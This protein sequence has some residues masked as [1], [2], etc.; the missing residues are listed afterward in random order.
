MLGHIDSACCKNIVEL[1]PSSTQCHHATAPQNMQ[2]SL[3]RFFL[4]KPCCVHQWSLLRH[5]QVK[6]SEESDNF[7]AD[8][9]HLASHSTPNAWVLV[10]QTRE[11][12]FCSFKDVRPLAEM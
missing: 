7:C 2:I 11:I 9:A 12:E 3:C 1:T 8:H 4:D 6:V 5:I 10:L